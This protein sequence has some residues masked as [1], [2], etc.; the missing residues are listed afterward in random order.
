[1][2]D[3][4]ALSSYKLLAELQLIISRKVSESDWNLDS[5]MEAI[6]DEIRARERVSLDR[7]SRQ[8][9]CKED[10]VPCTATTVMSGNAPTSCCYYNQTH[11][12]VK[13]S[14]VNMVEDRRQCLHNIG[15]CFL[16]L[17]RGHLL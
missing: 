10:K 8:I 11:S 1:M 16:C 5:L 9:P 3:Y 12:P 14:V 15:R 13:C 4:Y 17:R 2:V 6:E 7:L